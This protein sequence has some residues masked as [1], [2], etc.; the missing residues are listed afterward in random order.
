MSVKV[1][2]AAPDILLH[3]GGRMDKQG[4]ETGGGCGQSLSQ[5]HPPPPKVIGLEEE[6]APTARWW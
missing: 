3:F 1:L 5:D 2:S 6:E 4:E